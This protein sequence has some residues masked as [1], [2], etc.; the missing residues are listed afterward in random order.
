MLT[1]TPAIIS[2]L[3]HRNPR[4][5]GNVDGGVF[6]AKVNRGSPSER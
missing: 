3:Q 4:L 1:L 6:I 5:F 2:E